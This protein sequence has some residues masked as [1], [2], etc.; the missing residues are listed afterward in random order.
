M[1]PSHAR[2]QWTLLLLLILCPIP[3]RAEDP[4]PAPVSC[5]DAIKPSV[6]HRWTMDNTAPGSTTTIPDD[7]GGAPGTLQAGASLAPAWIQKGL[8]LNEVKQCLNLGVI[9]DMNFAKAT[10]FSISLW[11]KTSDNSG[12]LLTNGGKPADKY[13]GYSLGLFDNKLEFFLL[14]QWTSDSNFD[15]IGIRATQTGLIT[16]NQWH[17]VLATYDGSNTVLGLHLFVDGQPVATQ[18]TGNGSGTLIGEIQTT[19]EAYIGRR[20]DGWY[21]AFLTGMVDEVMILNRAL[22]ATEVTCIYQMQG[23]LCGDGIIHSLEFCDDGNVAAG[24]GCSATCQEEPGFT[25]PGTPGPCV[26]T[27]CTPPPSNM[28]HWWPMDETEG[29]ITANRRDASKPG[30][31][32]NGASFVTDAGRTALKLVR[33]NQQK[34]GLGDQL[35]DFEKTDPFSIALWVNTSFDTTS[36]AEILISKNSSDRGYQLMWFQDRLM[37]FLN[38][39]YPSDYIGIKEAQPS[40]Y[41]DGKWHLVTA[42]YEGTST[43]AGLHLYVDGQ[44]L[45]TMA[46]DDT[47]TALSPTA[48][49]RTTAGVEIGD[50]GWDDLYFFDGLFDEVMVFNRALAPDEVHNLYQARTLGVC[51]TDPTCDGID[52]DG[53]G[54]KNEDY[55]PQPTATTCGIG[56]CAATGMTS[57]TEGTVID[58]CTPLPASAELCDVI[59][60]DCDGQTDEDGICASDT[61]CDGIDIDGDGTIDDDYQPH[62]TACGVG[63]CVSTGVATCVAGK[64]LDSCA[65]LP[66]GPELCD[67]KDNNCDGQADE[68]GI[69]ESDTTC[70]GV[71]DDGDGKT[72]DNYPPHATTCGIGSCAT[73]GVTSC[74]AEGKELDSCTP[75]S[76]GAEVCDQL[77]NNCDGQVDEGEVCTTKTELPETP[78]SAPAPAPTPTP[79]TPAQTPTGSGTAGDTTTAPATGAS[80][81]ALVM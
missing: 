5:A 10:P 73:T 68:G 30:T 34:V 61:A 18:S 78:L 62:T 69:C 59:D 43:N 7:V 29:T 54:A 26:A 8:Q 23:P 76:G 48:S 60:N 57:C 47:K 12:T 75:L 44:L 38:G 4:P 51:T 49:I 52:D 41:N 31:L 56:A 25:C 6:L 74:A 11:V 20:T 36:G 3:L 32:H 21:G 50:R 45:P 35:M 80:G 81:C 37:F 40:P 24:D 70:N 65:T 66:G 19:A 58:V 33:A 28:I 42:T 64:E 77:D 17:H 67:G 22:A 53:D 72:D 71:D 79:G 39:P 9:A 2:I 14:S 27:T 13:A 16:N 1:N 63:A 55:Q 15:Y 46:Y